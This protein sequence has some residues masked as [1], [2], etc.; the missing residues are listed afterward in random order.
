MAALEDDGE[1]HA[2]ELRF[3][4]EQFGEILF[5]FEEGCFCAEEEDESWVGGGVPLVPVACSLTSAFSR[6]AKRRYCASPT[7]TFSTATASS[8]W[9]EW[10]PRDF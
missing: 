7:V 5:F 6:T 3:G 1:W 10:P 4:G 8:E 2:F 9:R